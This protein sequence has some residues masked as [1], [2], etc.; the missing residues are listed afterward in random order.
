MIVNDLYD[1]DS[2]KS[3][4]LK[5]NDITNQTNEKVINR[6]NSDKSIYYSSEILN[7]NNGNNNPIDNN[8][9]NESNN[10]SNNSNNISNK[11]SPPPLPPL[12]SQQPPP[13]PPLPPSLASKYKTILLDQE[14]IQNKL[15]NI[16]INNNDQTPPPLPQQPPP[17]PPLPSSASDQIDNGVVDLNRINERRLKG[18]STCSELDVYFKD[19]MNTAG[20]Q[21]DTNSSEAASI[22]GGELSGD[23]FASPILNAN[24]IS[25]N[26]NDLIEIPAASSTQTGGLLMQ[27][28]GSNNN[29]N[30]NQNNTSDLGGFLNSTISSN[31][32]S[33][34]GCDKSD[35]VNSSSFNSGLLSIDSRN[36]ERSASFIH[37]SKCEYFSCI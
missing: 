32:T 21:I 4:T 23:T 26:Q 16:N 7:E 29:N 36:D 3:A 9:I 34:G 11:L 13:L 31:N 2:S 24:I 17:L 18:M 1:S 15:A 27:T 14:Q 6:F 25:S 19:Y 37:D 5:S 28:N 33:N 20:P 10:S 35:S 22:S 30:C 8:D 12:P